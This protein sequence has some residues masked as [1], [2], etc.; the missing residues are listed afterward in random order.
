MFI[1]YA[2]IT[3]SDFLHIKTINTTALPTRE[4]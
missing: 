2:G 1:Q 3:L 4:N